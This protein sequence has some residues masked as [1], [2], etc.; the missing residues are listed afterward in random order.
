MQQ[1]KKKF[2][3]LN[4]IINRPHPIVRLSVQP[5][6]LMVQSMR[7]R[8]TRHRGPDEFCDFDANEIPSA[9]N[10]TSTL[11]LEGPSTPKRKTVA[12]QTHK[13]RNL[14]TPPPPL[15]HTARQGS[16]ST[17]SLQRY[18]LRIPANATPAVDPL[19]QGN[20]VQQTPCFSKA[21]NDNM[22]SP[23]PKSAESPTSEAKQ[24]DFV[25]TTDSQ[26]KMPLSRP[27]QNLEMR[28][29]DISSPLSALESLTVNDIDVYGHGSVSTRRIMRS[30]VRREQRAD[31]AIKN[32][33]QDQPENS[34]ILPVRRSSEQG[35][36]SALRIHKVKSSGQL[37]YYAPPREKAIDMAS[38]ASNSPAINP[39][40]TSVP[41]LESTR[42]RYSPTAAVEDMRQSP[43]P[44]PSSSSTE[45]NTFVYSELLKM[46]CQ[47]STKY[48]IPIYDPTRSV[49]HQF[50]S[51]S[52]TT[53]R[54][55][56]PWGLA[57]RWSCC[58]CSAQIIIEQK[59][60]AN[61]VC[62]HLRCDRECKIIWDTSK[63]QS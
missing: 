14:S 30:Q 16:P 9:P 18:K 46:G 4:L 44:L 19:L 11:L 23:S 15:Q 58:G 12:S 32:S 33:H 42:G 7:K 8:L 47:S 56:Q 57:K 63:H 5:V 39:R 38:K 1:V 49:E 51:R 40:A 53:S 20:S 50:C 24:P 60:C 43:N 28:T 41:A 31:S 6:H 17:A 52:S 13:G 62:G 54:P 34:G 48:I 2:L 22:M 35:V 10:F 27:S 3:E 25:A 21:Y 29:L 61:L 26:C 45:A 55:E 36:P 37:L 59:V